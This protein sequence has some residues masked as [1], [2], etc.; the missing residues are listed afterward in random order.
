MAICIYPSNIY[1]CINFCSLL[2]HADLVGRLYLRQ[3]KADNKLQYAE[4]S[5]AGAAGVFREVMLFMQCDDSVLNNKGIVS[6]HYQPLLQN[7]Y[8]PL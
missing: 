6:L 1:V 4:A 5:I 2:H 3:C 8:L 7:Q